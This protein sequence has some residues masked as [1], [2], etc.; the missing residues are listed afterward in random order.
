MGSV[1]GVV[2]IQ[3]R[4]SLLGWAGL[5][6]GSFRKPFAELELAEQADKGQRHSVGGNEGEEGEGVWCIQ[7]AAQGACGVGWGQMKQ[8]SVCTPCL[9]NGQAWPCTTGLRPPTS[10]PCPLPFLQGSRLQA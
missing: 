5:G 6:W 7:M 8:A 1:A 10:P 9:R 3:S 2:G 4:K